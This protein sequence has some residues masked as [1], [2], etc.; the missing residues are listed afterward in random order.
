MKLHHFVTQPASEEGMKARNAGRAL[1]QVVP[2]A[3]SGVELTGVSVTEAAK[4]ET[5]TDVGS[6][7]K[8]Q[9]HRDFAEDQLARTNPRLHRHLRHYG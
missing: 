9:A 4:K 6:A 3:L 1:T 7:D 8:V 5:V 2:V